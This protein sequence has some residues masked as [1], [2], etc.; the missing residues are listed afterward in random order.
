MIGSAGQVVVPTPGTLVRATV[1]LAEPEKVLP[2]HGIM[3]EVRPENTGN[4]YIGRVGFNK[5]TRVGC[6]AILAVPTAN[7]LPTFSV[8]ITLAPNALTL[9]GFYIDVDDAGDGVIVTYLQL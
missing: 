1:N 2:C 5:T 4:V 7:F 6:Y 9:D 3:F 8:A